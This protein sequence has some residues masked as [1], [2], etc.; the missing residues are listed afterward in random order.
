MPV[1]SPQGI[2]QL[3]RSEFEQIRNIVRQHLGIELRAGKEQ[4]VAARLSKVLRAKGLASFHQYCRYVAADKSGRALSTMAD[5]LTTNHTSLFREPAHFNF[6]RRW[7]A[8]DTRRNRIIRIWSA[9]C[10]TGEEAYSIAC[11]A[12]DE[13][14]SR[15]AERHVSILATDISSRALETGDRGVYAAAR[16]IEMPRDWQRRHLL[17]GTG[18][19]VGCYQFRPEIRSLIRFG[20]VNLARALPNLGA[21]TIIFCRN[22]LIYFDRDMQERVINELARRL[23]PSGLLFIGHSEGLSGFDHPLTYV[24]PAVYQKRARTGA[25]KR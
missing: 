18:R 13:L 7:F 21:F 11:C 3:R 14:G 4:F 17:R 15:A 24:C 5:A 2:F 9:G 16:F 6:L 25:S 23:E 22:V 1:D 12:A 8:G 10:A 20:R 19:W